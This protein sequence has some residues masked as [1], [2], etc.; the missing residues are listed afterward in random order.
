VSARKRPTEVD[1][2]VTVRLVRSVIGRPPD[3]VATVRTLGLRRI[4]QTVEIT[5]SPSLR[6]ML[7][8]VR[9]LVDVTEPVVSKTW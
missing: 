5:D 4:N 2:K 3:Q 7:T 1:T 6:G 8:K 9:H